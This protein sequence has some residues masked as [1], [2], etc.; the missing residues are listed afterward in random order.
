MTHQFSKHIQQHFPQL[1]DNKMLLAISGGIDSIVLLHLFFNQKLN[2]EVAHC[3]F[4]LRG[5]DSDL[6]QKLVEDY[7]QNHQIVCHTKK[8]DIKNSPQKS[9]QMQARELRYQWFN[10]LLKRRDLTQIVTAHHANDQIET[11]FINFSRGSG[12][13]GLSGM[14]VDKIIRPLLPFTK[15]ELINFAKENNI[16][17]REDTSNTETKYLR[18][19]IRHQIIPTFESINPSFIDSANQNIN[20]LKK[21]HDFFKQQSAELFTKIVEIKQ[22][23]W[24]ISIP[25]LKNI[26]SFELLL[27]DWLQPYG[28]HAWQDIYNLIDAQTGKLVL[29]KTHHLLKNRDELIL[30]KI[31]VENQEE[32][33]FHSFDDIH[34]DNKKIIIQEISNPSSSTSPTGAVGLIHI[35][36]NSL[37]FPLKIRK[38]QK[39]DYFYPFGMTGKKKLSK[40]FKDEK[41]SQNQKQ[42][43]WLLFAD[44]DL[45]WVINHRMDDR[46]KI[47]PETTHI[48][49]LTFIET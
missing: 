23:N 20:W 28:F 49:K 25:K 10:E 18:N 44:N 34:F 9:T 19:K 35:D 31:I 15:Q 40:F 3:N 48:L 5:H 47:K 46:F 24:L 37:K 36:K 14:S 38:F 21:H 41:F 43:T 39:G 13:E 16:I 32:Y 42:N 11:F 22:D 12:L 2:F 8:F 30:S 33:V 26:Q 1:K 6:D 27:F 45:V 7:C 4:Q 29:S 17:F